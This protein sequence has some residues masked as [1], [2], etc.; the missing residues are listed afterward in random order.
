MRTTCSPDDTG[1]AERER[2]REWERERELGGKQDSSEHGE[3][4]DKVD[5]YVN[6]LN[7]IHTNDYSK[8]GRKEG[9]KER[10]G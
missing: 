7:S 3:E 10:I 1:G 8:T 6:S 5:V 4:E 9:R 2:E